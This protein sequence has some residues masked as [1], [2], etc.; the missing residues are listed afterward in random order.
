MFV[1]EPATHKVNF[2]AIMLACVS[3]CAPRCSLTDIQGFL[4]VELPPL[5]CGSH[6]DILSEDSKGSPVAAAEDASWSDEDAA[7]WG[8]IRDYVE[9]ELADALS[10]GGSIWP[11]SVAMCR[12]LRGEAAVVRG[13][14]VLELGS[15]TGACGL[16]AGALGAR[17]V[18]L[19]D[20]STTLQ[21]LARANIARNAHLLPEGTEMRVERY[22]WGET[23]PQEGPVGDAGFDLVLASDVSY[24]YEHEAHAALARTLATL[25]RRERQQGAPRVVLTHEHRDRGVREVID[26]WDDCDEYLGLFR[27]ACRAEGLRLELLVAERPRPT[28]RG[29]FRHWSADLS[30]FE[31]LDVK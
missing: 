6:L 28:E 21:P 22:L 25:L 19:T 4:A 23:P 7:M 31:V 24:F 1:R 16:Y 13:A 15:G 17:S 10:V 26:A 14:S 3:R 8:R 20:G 9:D 11:A 5:A 29:S 18:T 2:Y 27:E 30:T 12:W